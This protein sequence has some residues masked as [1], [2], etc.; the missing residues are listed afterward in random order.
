[1]EKEENASLEAQAPEDEAACQ[2]K[3]ISKV[4]RWRGV[5]EVQ[6]G[7]CDVLERNG[8]FILSIYWT[9]YSTNA[10]H[11]TENALGDLFPVSQIDDSF[12]CIVRF[13][14]F[15]LPSMSSACVL[16]SSFSIYVC[17]FI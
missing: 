14:G 7:E 12:L 15:W 2:V 13:I 10:F 6:T 8:S 17:L 9:K 5:E 4:G 16:R 11:G 3:R 1:M